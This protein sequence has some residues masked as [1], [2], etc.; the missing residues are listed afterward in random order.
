MASVCKK[1]LE[2]HHTKENCIKIFLRSVIVPLKFVTFLIEQI[3][4]LKI[5]FL[6]RSS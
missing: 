4:R 1:I 5:D 3:Y 6:L 2:S